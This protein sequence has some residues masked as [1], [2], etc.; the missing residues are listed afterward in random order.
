MQSEREV[1]IA[2]LDYVH[3]HSGKEKE[4]E[5]GMPIVVAKSNRTQMILAT[6]APSKGVA[7]YAVEIAKKMAER[8]GYKKIILRSDNEPAILALKE[9]AR[10]EREREREREREGEK[11]IERAT[12]R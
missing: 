12:W 11:H 5:K 1:P 10:S 7:D 8:L 3:M 9:A 6:A 4:E 2:G